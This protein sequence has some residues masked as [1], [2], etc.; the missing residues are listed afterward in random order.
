MAQSPGIAGQGGAGSVGPLMP[1]PVS[2][3][4]S[5]SLWFS[6]Q[7][8]SFNVH[9]PPLLRT[10]SNRVWVGSGE[11]KSRKACD[12]SWLQQNLC[13]PDP[14]LLPATTA[15]PVPSQSRGTSKL[16]SSVLSGP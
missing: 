7:S 3:C 5:L 2:P 9:P 10:A 14:G 11:Q 12:L 13:E 6:Q 16:Q 1:R 15:K 4:L 8:M